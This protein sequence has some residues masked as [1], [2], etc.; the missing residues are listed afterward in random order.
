MTYKG[1]TALTQLLEAASGRVKPSFRA[2]NPNN[3]GLAEIFKPCL[4]S[5]SKELVSR[6]F[7]Y[8][9]GLAM[10]GQKIKLME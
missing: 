2:E 3:K 6:L 5:M 4:Y 1:S 7:P 10:K 9:E 8:E